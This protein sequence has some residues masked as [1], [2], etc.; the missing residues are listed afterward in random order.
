LPEEHPKSRQAARL[1]PSA[2]HPSGGGREKPLVSAGAQSV[3]KVAS[4]KGGPKVWAFA[5]QLFL[6]GKRQLFPPALGESQKPKKF[7]KTVT[8]KKKSDIHS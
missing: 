2:S 6:T 7:T 5:A 4:M 8:G 1:L 3:K